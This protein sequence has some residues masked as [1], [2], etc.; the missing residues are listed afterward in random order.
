MGSAQ[1]CS[2]PGSGAW[3]RAVSSSSAP[4]LREVMCLL[5]G[6][7]SPGL[8]LWSGFLSPTLMRLGTG[9]STEATPG[10]LNY[11]LA[12]FFFLAF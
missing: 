11:A 3:E 10:P 2:V 7:F 6:D 12:F 9:P 8:S 5:S 1:A 4:C